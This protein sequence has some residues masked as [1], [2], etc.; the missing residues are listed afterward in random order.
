MDREKLFES[1]FECEGDH[2][3]DIVKRM[4]TYLDDEQLCD[5]M[6]TALM[7]RCSSDVEYDINIAVEYAVEI[8][9]D[10]V[11]VSNEDIIWNVVN[12]IR[13]QFSYVIPLYLIGEGEYAN[14]FMK[15][16]ASHLQSPRVKYETL[17][18]LLKMLGNDLSKYI[19]NNEVPAWFDKDTQ[20]YMDKVTVVNDTPVGRSTILS[21]ITPAEVR[22]VDVMDI[23]REY[24]DDNAVADIERRLVDRFE[25]GQKDGKLEELIRNHVLTGIDIEDE[26]N[27]SIEVAADVFAEDLHEQGYTDD[28]IDDALMSGD[29][30]WPEFL[31][32][33]FSE[34]FQIIRVLEDLEMHREALQ[35][36]S[37]LA[38]QLIMESIGGYVSSDSL[39]QLALSIRK[40]VDLDDPTGWM[41]I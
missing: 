2:I 19:S 6:R 34:D 11:E 27:L 23:I 1:L 41:R 14:N 40:A 39:K 37:A 25:G 17:L 5:C 35:L 36:D 29:K 30:G 15:E 16:V 21:P 13:E 7:R 10:D 26:V 22:T 33:S 12:S 9:Y 18:P 20:E 32:Q 24:T 3:V 38:D 28:G 4:S 31:A 8:S